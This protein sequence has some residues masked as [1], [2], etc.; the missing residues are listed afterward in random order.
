MIFDYF[1]HNSILLVICRHFNLTEIKV[2]DYIFKTGKKNITVQSFIEEL[3][4]DL[5]IP[6]MTNKYIKY[7][8]CTTS[9]NNFKDIKRF[10]LLNSRAVLIK[11]TELNRFLRKNQIY[12]DLEKKQI[13][14]DNV[15]YDL[16]EYDYYNRSEL[17]ATLFIIYQKL[18]IFNGDL[19][20]FIY[21]KNK[22]I[23]SYSTISRYPEL[24]HNLDCILNIVRKNYKNKSI[25]SKW[26]NKK[27]KTAILN[28]KL[29]LEDIHPDMLIK[30]E[31]LTLNHKINYYLIDLFV[32]SY[33]FSD[34]EKCGI[35]KS[36]VTI[37]YQTI[38]F[39][40]E[41]NS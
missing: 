26:D 24:I 40:L 25:I 2:K 33:I 23:I 41:T 4:I 9:S 29:K 3:K 21:G 10:G 16:K 28:F 13:I 36:E 7:K 19:E 31:N 5:E 20:V 35:I 1:D 39:Q 22:N 18:Y 12:F 27:R 38:V 32:S 6:I 30:N 34:D 15:K 17:E 37:P 14:I 11:N 8:H